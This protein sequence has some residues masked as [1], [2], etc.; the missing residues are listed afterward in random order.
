M[1]E[2]PNK[3]EVECCASCKHLDFDYDCDAWCRKHD[4]ISVEFNWICDDYEK[5]GC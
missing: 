3:R 1:S 5:E 2:I 4:K